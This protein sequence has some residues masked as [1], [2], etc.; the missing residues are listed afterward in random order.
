[1]KYPKRSQYKYTKKLLYRIR[2]WR[3]YEQGLRNR[4]DLTIWISQAA[5]DGWRV[6]GKRKP[7]GK[8][9]YS[10]LA[11]ETCLTLGMVYGLRL[12]Q[13]EGFLQSLARIMGLNLPIPDHT[14]V[15]RRAKMLGKV[16]FVPPPGAGPLHISIDST[17]LKIHVGNRRK[18]P[19]S[20]DWRK[21]HLVLDL[22][23]GDIVAV[24]LTSRRATDAS[25]V[26]ALLKQIEGQV[27]SVLADGAYDREP[28]YEAVRAHTR[29]LRPPGVLIPPRKD[30]RLSGKAC[31]RDRDRHIRSIRR[32]GRRHWYKQSGIHLRSLVENAVYRYKSIIGR[33]MRARTLAGQRVEARIGCKILNTMTRLGM[34]D[35]YRV[36]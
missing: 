28:V 3:E 10:N 36:A 7:G 25:R 14:T 4:G 27:A 15:S 19:K 16:P 26:P 29:R 30:A 33:E 5:I 34:P 31:L 24:D 12:R 11:I 35:S 32:H 1:M 18:V 21:L 17:G 13:A 22:A 6:Q 8:R 20:R 9:I 23:S 2:N